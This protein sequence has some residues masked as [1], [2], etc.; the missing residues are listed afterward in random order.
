MCRF[1]KYW[2]TISYFVTYLLV[3]ENALGA[4]ARG[5]GGGAGGVPRS[6]RRRGGRGAK[7][8]VRAPTT[9][10]AEGRERAGGLRR[11]GGG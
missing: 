8:R 10:G 1:E 6:G 11:C 9:P 3:E 4:S 5:G 2:Q 7:D